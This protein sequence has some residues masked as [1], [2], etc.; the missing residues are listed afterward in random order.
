MKIILALECRPTRNIDFHLFL[1][2][3]SRT[4]GFGD[5]RFLVHG[6]QSV[7]EALQCLCDLRPCPEVV[8]LLAGFDGPQGSLWNPTLAL[9][10]R[11]QMENAER[12]RKLLEKQKRAARFSRDARNRA[13]TNA[14]S[15]SGDF[16]LPDNAS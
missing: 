4:E 12:V 5:M 9:R 3:L 14:L 13:A 2:A 10:K 6:G 1:V 15:I 7:A 8:Q 11:R 16:I